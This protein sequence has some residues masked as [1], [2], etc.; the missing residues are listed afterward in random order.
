MLKQTR[1]IAIRANAAELSIYYEIYFS[2]PSINKKARP[3]PPNLP[4]EFIK[5][6]IRSVFPLKFIGINSVIIIVATANVDP[7][8]IPYKNLHIHIQK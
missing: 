7:N 3:T 1:K 8:P 4:I 5:L 6:I 2:S